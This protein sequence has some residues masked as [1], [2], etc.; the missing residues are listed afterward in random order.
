EPG[1][2]VAQTLT[3]QLKGKHLLLLLDNCEHLLDACAQLVDAILRSCPRVLILATSREGLGIAGELTYRV[4]SL[5]LPDP[6]RDLKPESL[7]HFEAVQLFIERA[8]FHQPQ[9][10]VTNRNAPALAS[11]CY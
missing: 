10:A 11:V 8:E 1:Q 7:A 2:P 6:K 4:P 3:E 5:S 9:F